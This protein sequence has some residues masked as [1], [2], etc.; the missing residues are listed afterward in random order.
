[1]L[2]G[3]AGPTAFAILDAYD[4]HPAG[5]TV[6]PMWSS[7][8]GERAL[9]TAA[10]ALTDLSSGAQAGMTAVDKH[11]VRADNRVV[12]PDVQLQVTKTWTIVSQVLYSATDEPDLSS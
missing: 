6:D 3:K 11:L 2:T 10:R 5:S 7:A 12:G 8:S 9:T 4:E 1:K